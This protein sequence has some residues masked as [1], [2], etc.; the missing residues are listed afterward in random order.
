MQSF[1][2]C[3]CIIGTTLC[4][5]APEERNYHVFYEML[6]ALSDEQKKSYGLQTAPKYFYLNQ[7]SKAQLFFL[8]QQDCICVESDYI[9]G[10]S[11]TCCSPCA[12][13]IKS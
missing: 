13:L 1:S 2:F 5:Q 11:K 3:L 12:S 6:E 4:F 8:Y 9:F 7:V 10:T